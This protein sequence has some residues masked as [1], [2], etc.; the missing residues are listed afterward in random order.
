MVVRPGRDG[1]LSVVIGE[2]KNRYPISAADVANLDAVAKAF[3]TNLFEVFIVFA[4]ISPFTAEEIDLIRPLN[5][6]LR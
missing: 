5:Q 6:E 3:P 1:R 4:R 2:C